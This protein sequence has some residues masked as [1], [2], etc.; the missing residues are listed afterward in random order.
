MNE[1]TGPKLK[2]RSV[3]EKTWANT[4]R[5]SHGDFQNELYTIGEKLL[6]KF[7]RLPKGDILEIAFFFVIVLF[8]GTILVMTIIACSFCCFNCGSPDP[9]GRKI[10]VEPAAHK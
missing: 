8:I 1:A 6:N 7:Q 5:M 10:R 4:G 2:G 3:V 9:R